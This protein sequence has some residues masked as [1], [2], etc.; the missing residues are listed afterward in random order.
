LAKNRLRKRS[1]SEF[2]SNQKA[3]RSESE[4]RIFFCEANSL[5]FAIFRNPAKIA[6]I[7]FLE[8]RIRL[9]SLL[10]ILHLKAPISTTASH[11]SFLLARATDET[12]FFLACPIMPE[13]I[14]NK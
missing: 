10:K 4:C 2:F 5:R 8:T 7:F 13:K 6:K 9:F 1:E 3:K 12:D 11:S 14:L